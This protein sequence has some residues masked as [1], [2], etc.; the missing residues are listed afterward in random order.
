VFD[1]SEV[2]MRT[3]VIVGSS[4]SRVLAGRFVTPRGYRWSPHTAPVAGGPRG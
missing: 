2:D 4:Q 1:P 3:V